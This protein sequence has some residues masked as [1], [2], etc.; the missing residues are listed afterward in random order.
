MPPVYDAKRMSRAAITSRIRNAH[1]D[2]RSIARGMA[3]GALFVFLSKSAGAA[4]E[5]AVAWRYGVSE[6]VDSYLFI[7]NLVSWPVVVWFSVLSVVLVPLAATIREGK[8]KD[9][10]RFRAEL[11]GLT[12]LLG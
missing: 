2:H 10:C 12:F 11:L 3:M 8:P 6:V 1:P 4:K 7:F 9:L 5:M